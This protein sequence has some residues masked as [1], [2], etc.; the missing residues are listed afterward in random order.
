MISA[1]TCYAVFSSQADG[2]GLA[3]RSVNFILPPFVLLAAVGITGLTINRQA[4]HRKFLGAVAVSLCLGMVSVGIYS[5]YASVVLEEPYFGYFWRYNHQEYE[6]SSWIAT[7]VGNQTVAGDYKV[8][9]L[10]GEY[11]KQKVSVTDGLK[12]LDSDGT[13]P[14]LIYIYRQMYKNGYVFGSG[15]PVTLPQNWSSKLSGFNMIYVNSEVS[16]YANP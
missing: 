10:L 9:Y 12:Y 2:L 13:P 6:A 11:F 8:S 5:E 14:D 16:V 3:Y 15:T 1:F 7:G 4:N